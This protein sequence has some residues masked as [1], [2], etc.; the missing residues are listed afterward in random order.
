LL[1][2]LSVHAPLKCGH[3]LELSAGPRDVPVDRSLVE[4]DVRRDL[5]RVAPG[6]QAE[7]DLLLGER[8]LGNCHELKCQQPG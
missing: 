2:D 4:P 7:D 6:G 1:A 3:L 8:Q 5:A